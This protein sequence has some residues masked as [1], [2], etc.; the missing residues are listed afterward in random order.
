MRKIFS[1]VIVICFVMSLFAVIKADAIDV[2][3]F[4]KD[5]VDQNLDGNRGYLAGKPKDM[6]GGDRNI[7]RTLIGVDIELPAGS[8]SSDDEEEPE[9]TSKSVS[10]KKEPVKK[11]K[12]S[13]VVGDESEEAWIK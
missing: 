3:T 2:Y 4:K 6:T 12:P 10:K 7:K 5:R 8:S 11:S 9:K 1:L 13:T